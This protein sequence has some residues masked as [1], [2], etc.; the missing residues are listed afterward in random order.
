MWPCDFP[1][2]QHA[3]RQHV[4]HLLPMIFDLFLF[5]YVS[6][7]I[8]RAFSFRLFSF[9]GHERECTC[10]ID[11]RCCRTFTRPSWFYWCKRAIYQSH[12][13]IF[14]ILCSSHTHT[15]RSY[16]VLIFQFN[17]FF[18]SYWESKFYCCDYDEW[19]ENRIR[20]YLRSHC[21]QSA[22]MRANEFYDHVSRSDINH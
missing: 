16:V 17:S 5:I 14:N 15:L 12:A 11:A 19:P 1:F 2:A 21:Q 18:K 10:C 7:S 4:E 6:R 20:F 22:R 9:T 8:Y 3:H 13:T